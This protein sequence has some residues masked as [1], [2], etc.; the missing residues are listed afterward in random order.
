MTKYWDS[1]DKVNPQENWGQG[2]D[3]ATPDLTVDKVKADYDALYWKYSQKSAEELADKKAIFE[4]KPEAIEG[5][6]EK[7][8]NKI[9]KDKYGYNTFDEAKAILGEGFYKAATEDEDEDDINVRLKSLETERKREAYLREQE[10]LNN[11]IELTFAR[12]PYLLEGVENKEEAIKKEMSKLSSSLSL[13]ERIDT[14]VLLIESRNR[15]EAPSFARTTSGGSKA[16]GLKKQ[17]NEPK[18]NPTLGALF[19]NS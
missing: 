12:N 17:P 7:I 5:F 10:S 18:R 8:K 16:E 6:S 11:K 14:A 15:K 13:E 19:G 2:G 3:N 1:A 9:V 4:F